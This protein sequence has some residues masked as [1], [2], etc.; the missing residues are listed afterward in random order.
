MYG[1]VKSLI[2]CG[3]LT[4]PAGPYTVLHWS[5]YLVVISI[6]AILIALLLPALARVRNVLGE[7]SEPI[8]LN[9]G[10][11]RMAKFRPY[12]QVYNE[13]AE[14][15]IPLYAHYLRR[16]TRIGFIRGHHGSGVA[17]GECGPSPVMIV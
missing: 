17:I 5:N 15:W 11:C 1:V 7:A 8:G 14:L 4:A 12:P 16:Q 9:P 3:S 2:H 10:G 6:I 13:T